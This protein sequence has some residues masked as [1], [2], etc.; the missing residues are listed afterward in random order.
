MSGRTFRVVHG[1]MLSFVVHVMF[2]VPQDAVRGPLFFIVYMAD[3]AHR[4]V[5]YG[6]S[7]R[8]RRRHFRRDEMASS[9]D[10]LVRCDL[11]IGHW[12]SANRLN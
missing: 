1:V 5:K 12:M 8:I 3:I 11:D 7:S 6:V 4:A 2:W 10:Q 9:A